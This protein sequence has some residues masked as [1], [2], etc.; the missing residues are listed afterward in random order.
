MIDLDTSTFF[1]TYAD[2]SHR[3]DIVRIMTGNESGL[4]GTIIALAIETVVFAG[5]VGAVMVIS[6]K[7]KAVA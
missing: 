1:L 5:V 4:A 3:Q 2:K 7:K 6:K